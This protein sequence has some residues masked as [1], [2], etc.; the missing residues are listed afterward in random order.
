MLSLPPAPWSW[1]MVASVTE[2]IFVLVASADFEEER[3][4]IIPPITIIRTTTL[5]IW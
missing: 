4:K 2:R 1:F 3:R 5:P